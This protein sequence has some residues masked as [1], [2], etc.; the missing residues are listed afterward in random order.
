MNTFMRL[1]VLLRIFKFLRCT[2]KY[3]FSS[4]L[5]LNILVKLCSYRKKKKCIAFNIQSLRTLLA[6][7]NNEKV[8]TT[9]TTGFV[10]PTKKKTVNFVHTSS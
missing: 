9:T 4:I 2:M 7:M 8:W 6:S 10:Y 1:N 5:S 3:E